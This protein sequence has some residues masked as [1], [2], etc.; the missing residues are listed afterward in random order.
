[1]KNRKLEPI[2]ILLH[3]N[4]TPFLSVFCWEA[5]QDEL[6][7]GLLSGQLRTNKETYLKC[8][9]KMPPSV[10][11]YCKFIYENPKF[12]FNWETHKW[13]EQ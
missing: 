12:P 2:P 3:K 6:T 4:G 13:D 9:A 7:T 10:R 5:V 11:K 1:M 8:T